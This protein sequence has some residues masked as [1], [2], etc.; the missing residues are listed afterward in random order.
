MQNRRMILVG[1]ILLSISLSMIVLSDSKSGEIQ[2]PNI[3]KTKEEAI[4]INTTLI[5]VSPKPAAPGLESIFAIIGLTAVAYLVLS[6]N[7]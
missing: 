2:Y 5:T 4:Q 6:K 3:W 7:Q 1:L